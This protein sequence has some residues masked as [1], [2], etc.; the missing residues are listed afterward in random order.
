MREVW[1][2]E[3]TRATTEEIREAA[4]WMGLL[5]NQPAFGQPGNDTAPGDDSSPLEGELGPYLQEIP[6]S[7]SV[8]NSS[9]GLGSYTWIVGELGRVY[10]AYFENDR[11]YAGFSGRYP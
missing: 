1:N 9:A 6:E 3:G 5:V 11:W 10:G 4:I 7:C 8:Y 2:E